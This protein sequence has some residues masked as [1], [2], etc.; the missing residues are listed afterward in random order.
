MK[1]TGF[2]RGTSTLLLAAVLASC[3]VGPNFRTPAAPDVALTPSPLPTATP[4]ANGHVQNFVS[5][6]DI[7]GDWWTMFH[8]P[9]LNTLIAAALANN[10]TLAAAQATL[11]EAQ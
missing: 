1:P 2:L 9:E 3:A 4:A 6:A 10:P 11:R 5:A 7:A 8:S